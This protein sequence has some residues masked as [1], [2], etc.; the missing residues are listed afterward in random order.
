MKSRD[1]MTL[2]DLLTHL[3][4]AGL[5]P[6]GL[7]ASIPLHVSPPTASVASE[8]PADSVAAQM[9]QAACVSS[10]WLICT[11]ENSR[12]KMSCWADLRASRHPSNAHDFGVTG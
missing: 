10:V 11:Q 12:W 9:V 7:A 6:G 8:R 4:G 2:S 3:T 1:A 5:L